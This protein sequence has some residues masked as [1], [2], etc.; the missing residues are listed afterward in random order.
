MGTK[1][2]AFDFE[3]ALLPIVD[4]SPPHVVIKL[5]QDQIFDSR[6]STHHAFKYNTELST[7]THVLDVQLL[8]KTNI[9]PVQAIKIEKLS[10]NGIADSRFIWNGIYYPEY[11]EPWASEQLALGNI[12][13]RQL[14]NTD[15]MGW[16][17]HWRLEFTSPIFTW[18][19]KTC[20]LGWIYE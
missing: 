10:L 15:Y 8:D 6:L 12:L 1:M 16:N 2:F 11:P 9:D 7:G 17:G 14:H 5:D 18:I 20:S 4:K 3:L 13:P 19:H